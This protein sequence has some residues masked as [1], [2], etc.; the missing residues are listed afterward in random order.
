MRK[1]SVQ[2]IYKRQY[3]LARYIDDIKLYYQVSSLLKYIRT[4]KIICYKQLTMFENEN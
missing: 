4:P 1:N 3:L 2:H